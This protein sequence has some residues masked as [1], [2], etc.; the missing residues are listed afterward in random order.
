MLQDGCLLWLGGPSLFWWKLICLLWQSIKHIALVQQIVE[1]FSI[2]VCFFCILC[3]VLHSA[4]IVN[5]KVKYYDPQG[6]PIIL[7]LGYAVLPGQCCWSNTGAVRGIL[8][9]FS[10]DNHW[11]M[12]SMHSITDRYDSRTSKKG[13]SVSI[14]THS[15][16]FNTVDVVTI[17]M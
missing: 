9:K 4:P 15:S 3:N 5:V 16:S 2:A 7:G 1:D 6:W 14:Y 12:V 11:R 13:L 10:S 8:H 17:S